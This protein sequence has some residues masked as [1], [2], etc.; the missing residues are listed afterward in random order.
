MTLVDNLEKYILEN[1][2]IQTIQ[3]YIELYQEKNEDINKDTINEL[4]LEIKGIVDE[5]LLKLQEL[6]HLSLNLLLYYNSGV[7]DRDKKMKFT[8]RIALDMYFTHWI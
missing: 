5:N 1:E 3:N 8:A 2:K 6:K 4:K 7:N